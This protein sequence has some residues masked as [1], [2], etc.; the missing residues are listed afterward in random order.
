MKK[1]TDKILIIVT[2]ILLLAGTIKFFMSA[3]EVKQ[4]IKQYEIKKQ[5]EV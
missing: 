3:Y 4:K 1:Y 2:A 5:K